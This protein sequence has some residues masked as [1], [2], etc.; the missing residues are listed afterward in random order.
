MIDVMIMTEYQ[1]L[2]YSYVKKYLRDISLGVR[3]ISL[4]VS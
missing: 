1:F 4:G 3:E 2:R